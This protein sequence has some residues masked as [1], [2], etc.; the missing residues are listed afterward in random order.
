M[1]VYLVET[2]YI[3]EKVPFHC[4]YNKIKY[5]VVLQKNICLAVE[6][7]FREARELERSSY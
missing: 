6:R 3:D 4:Y 1:F 5:F 2:W 7:I